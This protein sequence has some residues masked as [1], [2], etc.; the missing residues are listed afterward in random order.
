MVPCVALAAYLWAAWP[1]SVCAWVWLS[2]VGLAFGLFMGGVAPDRV[3]V[4]GGVGG[5]WWVVGGGVWV[6]GGWW[7]VVGGWW[8][9]VVVDDG[10]GGW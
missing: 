8:W 1:V 7:L 6:V 3:C 10:G 4:G 2:G 9:V 5:G